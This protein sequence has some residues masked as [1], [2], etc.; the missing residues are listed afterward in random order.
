MGLGNV[1]PAAFN[2]IAAF[3]ASAVANPNNEHTT[4]SA[5]LIFILI[6]LLHSFAEL[7][8]PRYIAENSR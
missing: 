3:A 1:A 4:T 7:L 5:L 2:M 8:Q 6:L